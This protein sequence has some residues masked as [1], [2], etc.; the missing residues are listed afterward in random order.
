MTGSRHGYAT[1]STNILKLELNLSHQLKLNFHVG[2]YNLNV[3]PGVQVYLIQG[4]NCRGGE[5]KKKNKQ[6]NS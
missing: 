4:K 3:F 2:F 6:A 1:L 5:K